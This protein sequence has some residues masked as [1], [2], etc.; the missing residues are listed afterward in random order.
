MSA[1]ISGYKIRFYDTGIFDA[2]TKDD[3]LDHAIMIVGYRS[4]VGWR[5]KN[6]WGA[7]WGENGFGWLA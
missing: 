3:R 2:C 4:R 7:D 6:S 5:I 1:A